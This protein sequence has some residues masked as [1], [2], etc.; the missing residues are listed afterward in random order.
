MHMADGPG[1]DNSAGSF[2]AEGRSMSEQ[3]NA[4][5]IRSVYAAFGRGDLEGILSALHS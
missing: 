2:H 4:D 3:Q 5:T 1:D